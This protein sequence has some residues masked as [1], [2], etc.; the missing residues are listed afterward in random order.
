[1][2][3]HMGLCSRRNNKN[4]PLRTTG[5]GS[6]AAINRF[7]TTEYIAI[8]SVYTTVENVVYCICRSKV[9]TAYT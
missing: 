3:A 2:H 4:G 9:E 8:V 5:D 1:M 7:M 6:I